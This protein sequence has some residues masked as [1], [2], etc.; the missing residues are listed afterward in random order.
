MPQATTTQ[1]GREVLTPEAEE[2]MNN[3][4]RARLSAAKRAD[5]LTP[6]ASD[7]APTIGKVPLE[8]PPDPPAP[9]TEPKKP[10]PQIILSVTIPYRGRI[11]TISGEGLNLDSF[12]DLLDKRLGVAE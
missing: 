8:S 7:G 5:V 12:C 11:I 3:R 1:A 4:E 6:L 9:A 10:A 2:I